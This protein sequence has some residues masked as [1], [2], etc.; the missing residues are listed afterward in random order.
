MSFNVKG[1]RGEYLE[2]VWF[3]ENEQQGEEKGMSRKRQRYT[4]AE[5]NLH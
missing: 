3:A 4:K 2:D 5:I 1:K